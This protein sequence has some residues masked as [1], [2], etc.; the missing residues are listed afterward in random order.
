RVLLL[1]CRRQYVDGGDAAL[2]LKQQRWNWLE[3][4]AL[5][6]KHGAVQL[7]FVRGGVGYRPSH[8]ADLRKEPR[9]APRCDW[10]ADRVGHARAHQG[11]YSPDGCYLRGACE[12]NACAEYCGGRNSIVRSC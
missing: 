10:R 12:P 11:E 1:S 7:G 3:R 6:T 9:T 4:L 2:A 5:A 8:S